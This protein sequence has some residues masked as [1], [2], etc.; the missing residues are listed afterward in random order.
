MPR[1]TIDLERSVLRHLRDVSAREGKSRGALLRSSWQ[2]ASMKPTTC[3]DSH[4]AALMRQHG[5]RMIHTRDS[6]FRRFDGLD[7][8][9]PLN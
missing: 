7:V 4:H 5:V 3:L 8:R 1:T 2:R 6:G 9:D